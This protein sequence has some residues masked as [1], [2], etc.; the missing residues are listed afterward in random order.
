MAEDSQACPTFRQPEPC[1]GCY[2]WHPYAVCF[3]MFVISL[4]ILG[5][6]IGILQFNAPCLSDNSGLGL[7]TWLTS[8]SLYLLCYEIYFFSDLPAYWSNLYAR[9]CREKI[10]N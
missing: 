4:P 2:F 3:V 9:I 8:F 1:D 7:H 10:R 5:I 6:V